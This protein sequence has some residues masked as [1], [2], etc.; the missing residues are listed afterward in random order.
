LAEIP[1]EI[2][3]IVKEAQ[4]SGEAITRSVYGFQG[5]DGQKHVYHSLEEMPSEIRATYESIL[6]QQGLLGDQ[7]GR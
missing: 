1:P 3:A 4:A 5:P 6:K 7:A 2:Q